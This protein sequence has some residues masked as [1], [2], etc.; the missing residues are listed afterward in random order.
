MK[1]VHSVEETIEFGREI[2]AQLQPGDVLALVGDLGAGKT[3]LTKG[4]VAGLGSAAEVTSPTFTLVHEYRDGQIPAFHFDFYR[5]DDPNE[6]LNIGWDDFSRCGWNRDRRVGGQVSRVVSRGDNLVGSQNGRGRFSDD[7]LYRVE[8]VVRVSHLFRS[9]SWGNSH[10]F[11][12]VGNRGLS[13][14]LT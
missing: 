3:H 14:R 5:L 7:Q 12:Y 2:A 9:A 1:T 13:V 8:D 4:I 10:E 6:L 11:L